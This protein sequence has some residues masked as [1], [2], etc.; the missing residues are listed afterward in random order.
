L[1]DLI[2]VITVNLDDAAG[3]RATAQ[4]VAAQ[5]R[6]PDQWIV[7]D[8]GSMD[9]S[10][11]VIR[12]FEHLI[13]RW[14]SAPDRGVYD[15]MNRGLRSARGRYVIFMNS[16]DRFAAPD[17]LALIAAALRESPGVDLLFGGTILAFRSGGTWYRPPH[18]MA[19]LRVGLPACHQATAIRRAAHLLLPYDL[20]L[21][22][23][24]EYGT[25]AALI[26]RGATSVRL[27]RAI[28][29]RACH[30]DGLSERATPRRFADF[31]AVQRQILGSGVLTLGA[32]LARLALAHCLHA[33]MRGL[34]ASRAISIG[35]QE[36]G[37]D[38]LG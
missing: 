2:S 31:V 26:T 35:Q 12:E 33:A 23:S 30:G 8:G 16:G 25:I 22:V 24:A 38:T 20:R 34:S 15:A 32:A 29:V 36:T 18:A 21:P 10:I 4:S 13:D 11:A 17:S 19:R 14:S 27:D 37:T 28:A 5:E 6:P 9:G 3:L 1:T 7:V